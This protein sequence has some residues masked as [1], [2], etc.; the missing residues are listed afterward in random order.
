MMEGN[1][2]GPG[3]QRVSEY[4]R[5]FDLPGGLT[6]TVRH[7]VPADVS[8]LAEL[9]DGLSLDDRY[10]RFFSG[11][12]PKDFVEKWMHVTEQG[13]VGLVAAVANGAEH[14]VA[15]AGFALL[16]DGDGELA[17]A[18]AKESARLAR[19]LP[20]RTALVQE[21]AARGIPNLQAE[22]LV[23]NGAMFSLVRS[24]GYAILDHGDWSSVRVTVGMAGSPPSWPEA[25]ERPRVLVETPG[26]RWPAANVGASG[27]QIIGCP[28]P[29]RAHHGCPALL[30][31]RPCPLAAHAD[32][33]VFVF[34]P[35]DAKAQETA[36]VHTVCMKTS[37]SSSRPPTSAEALVIL[38]VGS[39][40][41]S[42]CALRQQSSDRL[43][44]EVAACDR[45]TRPPTREPIH[46]RMLQ[47][48]VIDGPH[49][50]PLK[51]RPGP[52]A[53]EACSFALIT[54]RGRKRRT[55][56]DGVWVRA[57]SAP[58][59]GATSRNRRRPC[60][61]TTRRS[62]PRRAHEKP[63]AAETL[64]KSGLVVGALKVSRRGRLVEDRPRL[65]GISCASTSGERY[66]S[67][68]R[69]GNMYT[70]SRRRDFEGALLRCRCGAASA[71]LRAVYST[72][73]FPRRGHPKAAG[74]TSSRNVRNWMTSASMVSSSGASCS[75]VPASSSTV[76]LTKS[77]A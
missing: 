24:R 65:L 59:P 49:W 67:C 14:I 48:R 9:Y 19:S 7:S 42:P 37:R 40:P 64:Q 23:D 27:L 2:T 72:I 12:M 46:R 74:S 33:I 53:T 10:H 38:L 31:G 8:G 70:I 41:A 22:I 30:A 16:P 1:P 20:A 58:T 77:G 45:R 5:T 69:H 66:I 11:S 57:S 75:I 54:D 52:T 21:A 39:A 51:S 18:V 44:S 29:T 56:G 3:D 6:M 73:R 34:P 68:D 60:E 71:P 32:V 26:G 15:E 17:L 35:S 47:P 62:A 55:I 63:H 76:S 13:G 61:P 28:G 43:G 50:M 4:R 25:D 36:S